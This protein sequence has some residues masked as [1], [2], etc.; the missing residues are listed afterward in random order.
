MATDDRRPELAVVGRQMCTVLSI[1]QCRV[2]MWSHGLD[3]A[4]PRPEDQATI[5]HGYWC[6]QGMMPDG[7]IGRGSTRIAADKNKSA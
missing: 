5:F 1:V 7:K 3:D 2:V 4:P 6:C